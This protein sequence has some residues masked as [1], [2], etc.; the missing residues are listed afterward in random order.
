MVKH[1]RSYRIH[2]L[3]KLNLDSDCW[4]PHA[5]VLWEEYGTRRHQRLTGPDD[6]FKIIDQAEL[7]AVEMAKSWIDED[8]KYKQPH[9]LPNV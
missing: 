9:E 5:E 3:T 7:H 4:I 2:V 6:R 8:L 1:Y